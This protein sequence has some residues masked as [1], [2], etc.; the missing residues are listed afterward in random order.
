MRSATAGSRSASSRGLI[1][2]RPDPA[3]TCSHIDPESGGTSSSCEQVCPGL[4]EADK[5]AAFVHRQPTV[6]NGAVDS[7]SI[8]GRRS[9]KLVQEWPVDL[10]DVDAAILN[11]LDRTGDL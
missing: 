4:R 2:N 10:L 9:A 1:F 3:R 5:G 6:R 7:G 8:F 11:R